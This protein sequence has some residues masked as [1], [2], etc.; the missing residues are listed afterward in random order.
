MI[1]I[2]VR[3]INASGIGTYISHVVPGIVNTLTSERFTLIGNPKDIE[4]LGIS[5]SHRVQIIAASSKMY[6]LY[7]QVEMP[8]LIPA[9]TRLYFSPHYPIPLLYRGKVLVTIHDVFHLAMPKLVGGIHKLLYAKLMFAQVCK[10][11]A[12]IIT[13]SRFTKSELQQYL[14]APLPPIHTIHLGVDASWFTVPE[15]NPIY[16]RPYL[17]FVGNIKPN[18]NLVSLIQ[19]YISVLSVIPH[20]LVIV[21][22]KSGF[23]TTDSQVYKLASKHP[24]RIIFTDVLPDQDLKRYV[25]GATALIFPSLYEGFG[26]PP[27][28]A[29]ACACPVLS[30]D[31]ASLPEVC[32]EA[33]LYCDPENIEDIARQIVRIASDIPLQEELRAKGLVQAQRFVWSKCVDQTVEVIR[34]L[35]Q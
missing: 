21:G 11:A 25:K 6:S 27:L 35:I 22:K 3:W 19:A 24:D 12:A 26:L 28:E 10:K 13:V 7:E 18:K 16:P 15:S 34:G 8:R 29:M 31:R 1:A 32:G 14:P 20:D 33:A 2:D 9:D 5:S 4:K 17:V 23:I 30:S